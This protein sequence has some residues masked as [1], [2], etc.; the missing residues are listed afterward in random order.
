MAKFRLTGGFQPIPEGVY[1]F[2]IDKV[3]YDE[4]FGKMSITLKTQTGRTHVET[5]RFLKGD[6]KTVNDGAMAAFSYFTR[7]AMNDMDLEELDDEQDLVGHF[8][9]A[10]V[11]HEVTESTKN[12]GQMF[13]N[14]RLNDKEPASGWDEE[15]EPMKVESDS[16]DDP[17]DFLARLL[18]K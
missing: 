18:K 2:K 14:V 17:D 12:P 15:E 10:T 9:K 6:G 11:E 1:V 8:L 4:D 7:I 5:F 13:T 16:D 3:E